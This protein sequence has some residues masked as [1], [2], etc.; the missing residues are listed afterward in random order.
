MRE[1]EDSQ[2]VDLELNTAGLRKT[3]T[4]I[5]QGALLNSELTSGMKKEITCKTELKLD[6]VSRAE[7][8]G[9]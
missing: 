3:Q 2:I 8:P 9:D 4:F 6:P 7:T 1:S 5:A